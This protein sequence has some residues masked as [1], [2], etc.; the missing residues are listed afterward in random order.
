MKRT[1]PLAAIVLAAGKG[2]RMK[3]ALPKVLH[4]VAGKTI[5]GHILDALRGLGAEKVVV[6][7]GPEQA[8][9]AEE[10]KRFGAASA[11]QRE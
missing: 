10:A 6:V 1:K 4:A 5:L 9:V 3:S 2:T 11:V 8:N 7:V